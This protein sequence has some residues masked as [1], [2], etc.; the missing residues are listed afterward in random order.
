MRI[1]II[2]LYVGFTYIV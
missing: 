1:L 2:Y